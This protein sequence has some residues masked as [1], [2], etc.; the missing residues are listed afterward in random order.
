MGIA[1]FRKFSLAPSNQFRNRLNPDSLGPA[2]LPVQSNVPKYAVYE[3]EVPVTQPPSVGP[4]AVYENVPPRQPHDH[5]HS[6][7]N[8]YYQRY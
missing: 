1:I 6:H 7:Q 3:T 2:P 4:Y 8:N 5:L